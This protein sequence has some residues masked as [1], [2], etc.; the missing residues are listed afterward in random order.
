MLLM[1]SGST[2]EKCTLPLNENDND[3]ISLLILLIEVLSSSSLLLFPLEV[4]SS[5]K[6]IRIA[7]PQRKGV[8][9]WPVPL[10]RYCIN[11]GS[12]NH[13]SR[14]LGQKIQKACTFEFVT[15]ITDEFGYR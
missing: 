7:L 9:C 6:L 10:Q 8:A 3:P 11:E 2:P 1:H 12:L 13:V 15:C 14:L 4:L 5:K